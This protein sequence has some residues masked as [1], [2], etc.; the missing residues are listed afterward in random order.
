MIETPLVDG[1]TVTLRG[2][3]MAFEATVNWELRNPAQAVLDMG[4]VTAS[5]GGPGRGT[6]EVTLADLARGAYVFEAYEA[7]AE[8]GRKLHNATA[9]FTIS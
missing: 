3:A 7:S 4:F 1:S 6:W 8:D 5:E 2:T 9:T